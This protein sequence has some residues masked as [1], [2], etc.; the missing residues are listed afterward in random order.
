[1]QQ[2]QNNN[3]QTTTTHKT[4]E[5]LDHKS[6]TTKIHNESPKS[7]LRVPCRRRFGH[8]TVDTT[9]TI[10]MSEVVAAQQHKQLH[11]LFIQQL[12]HQL[13]SFNHIRCPSS[14]VR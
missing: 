14:H 7:H 11:W 9:A 8:K 10:P 5:T 4:K 6:R 12:Y 3:N 2:Q 13:S 1:M